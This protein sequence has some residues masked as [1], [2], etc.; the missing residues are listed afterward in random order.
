MSRFRVHRIV[1]P[2]LLYTVKPVLERRL[3]NKEIMVL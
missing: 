3:Q 1:N 2:D